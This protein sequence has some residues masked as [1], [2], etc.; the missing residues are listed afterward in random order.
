MQSKIR[1]GDLIDD[2]CPRCRLLLDH[3][4]ASM[5]GEQVAKVVCRTCF[6]EHPYRHGKAGKKKKSDV[7]SLMAEL[8]ARAPQSPQ[9]PPASTVDEPKAR[10]RSP[11]RKLGSA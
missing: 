4:V 1:L 7:E 8:L 9:T 6:N 11:R 3:S 10:P 2:Y 5:V